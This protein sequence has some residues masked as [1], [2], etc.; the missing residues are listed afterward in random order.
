[1]HNKR[2]CIPKNPAAPELCLEWN[3][4]KMIKELSSAICTSC[5][6]DRKFMALKINCKHIEIDDFK[7]FR[8]EKALLSNYLHFT[9]EVIDYQALIGLSLTSSFN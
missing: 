6:F 9:I 3:N 1:V 7:R 2:V 5:K 4:G 8:G